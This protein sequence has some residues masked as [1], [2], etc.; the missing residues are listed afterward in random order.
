MAIE[1]DV[2]ASSSIHLD[3][4]IKNALEEEQHRILFDCTNLNYISSAGLGVFVSY[5]KDFKERSGKFAFASMHPEVLNVFRMLG[6]HDVLF[7]SK[8]EEEAISYLNEG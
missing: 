1:G 7:I 8:T 5:I 6:L 3:S 2:D 4:A